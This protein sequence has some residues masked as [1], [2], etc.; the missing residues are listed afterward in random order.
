MTLVKRDVRNSVTIERSVLWPVV[1][2]FVAGNMV[3]EEDLYVLGR[4]LIKD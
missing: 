4:Y 2:E 3:D 1:F